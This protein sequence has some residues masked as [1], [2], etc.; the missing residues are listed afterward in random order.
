MPSLPRPSPTHIRS[1]K[2]NVSPSPACSLC[3]LCNFTKK[4]IS[5]RYIV[6]LVYLSTG[7]K[8]QYLLFIPL[9]DL[10]T[11]D[12]KPFRLWHWW[13]QI[14]LWCYNFAPQVFARRLWP[15]NDW[16][17][18]HTIHNLCSPLTTPI[19][20]RGRLPLAF[21]A[22]NYLLG[23]PVWCRFCRSLALLALHKVNYL[24]VEPSEND[25]DRFW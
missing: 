15:C 14:C 7:Q 18:V 4:D 22:V 10:S 2:E 19:A 3:I 13:R 6:P 20:G 21:F 25:D 23:L 5:T 11:T 8:S 17:F 9:G 12:V 1:S 16:S 24:N